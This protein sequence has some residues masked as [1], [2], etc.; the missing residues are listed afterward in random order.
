[1]TLEL[2][3]MA[4][5]GLGMIALLVHRHMEITRGIE[6][7]AAAMRQKADPVLRDI[8]RSTGRIASRFTLHTFVLALNRAFVYAVRFFMDISH[9]AHKASADLVEKAS[10]K[11]EDLSK[12]G[13]ASF[14]LKQIKDAKDHGGPGSIVE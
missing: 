9:K 8:H 5:S 4:V 7:R 1:M 2:T 14:Y 11:T 12:R 10:R 6:T 13:A 3:L